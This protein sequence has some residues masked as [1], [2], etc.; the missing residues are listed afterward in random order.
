[1][2]IKLKIGRKIFTINNSDVMKILDQNRED[3][4]KVGRSDKFKDLFREV[5]RNQS[6]S[7]IYDVLRK[8][9][10]LI[11]KNPQ[12][13]ELTTLI[14]FR[15]LK[16]LTING[17]QKLFK[18]EYSIDNKQLKLSVGKKIIKTLK[19]GEQKENK[20]EEYSVLTVDDINPRANI[21]SRLWLKANEYVHHWNAQRRTANALENLNTD[22]LK[23]IGLNRDDIKRD[24][25]RPFWR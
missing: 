19:V 18:E 10:E 9:N 8:N 15:R 22:Q 3:A 25:S 5:K 12:N 11:D 2:R 17:K 20:E 21:W 4:I 24:Y 7:F 1:M 16:S 6:L 23:D 13:I 14:L